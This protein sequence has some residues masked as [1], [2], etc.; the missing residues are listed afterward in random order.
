[1]KNLFFLLTLMFVSTSFTLL[2]Q[3]EVL[4]MNVLISRNEPEQKCFEVSLSTANPT[5]I[6]ILVEGETYIK[7]LTNSFTKEVCYDKQETCY[8]E[9]IECRS[10]F[11]LLPYIRRAGAGRDGCVVTIEPRNAYVDQLEFNCP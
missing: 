10:D 2:A 3:S 5:T 7:L 8:N 4:S 11:A 9:T 1:M 6:Y